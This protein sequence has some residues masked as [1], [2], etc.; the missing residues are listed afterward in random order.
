ML[1]ASG[2]KQDE[3][4]Y[5]VCVYGGTSAGVIAATAVYRLGKSVI[6]ISPEK[7]LGGLTS[8]GLGQTDIGNKYA[9]TGLARDFYRRIGKHYGRFEKWTFE[10]HV[11]EQVFNDYLKGTAITVVEGYHIVHARKVGNRVESILIRPVKGIGLLGHRKIIAREFIDCSY[12]GDMMANCKVS[13]TFGREA[14]TVY[15]ETLNGVQLRDKH[16]FPDGIDPFTR[17]GDPSSGLLWGIGTD[18][19]LPNGTG[20][21]KIQAYN[22]RLCLTRDSNNVIPIQKPFGYSAA[23]YELLRRLIAKQVL[24]GKELQLG[25]YMHIQEMPN[26]K[27]DINNNGPFSTDYI[28]PGWNYPESSYKRRIAIVKEH[29]DYIK[30][31]LYY[32]GHDPSVP[33]SLRRQMLE[34]GYAKDEFTDNGGFPWQLYVREA[35]RMLG[36]YVMTEANCTGK[37]KVGDGVGLA[38]YTMDSHNCD[39][40]VVHGMVKNEG[41][42]Q[43]GGFPPYPVSYRAI[44]PKI[45]ECTNLLVPVCLSSSHIAYG[46][47]RMEPVFMVLA[48]SAALAAA[49]A[50][51]GNCALQNVDVKALKARLANDPLFDGSPA[52]VLVDNADE[53]H[54]SCTGEWRQVKGLDQYG[55][56]CLIAKAP[57]K[58]K[59][60]ATFTSGE[61]KAGNWQ[62]YY[63]CPSKPADT[64]GWSGNLVFRLG[65]GRETAIRSISM[66]GMERNWVTLGSL[67]VSGKQAVSLELLADEIKAPVFADALLLVFAGE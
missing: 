34:W 44:I 41:D 21:N 13:Y 17:I 30:G 54:F 38:A 15:G 25:N 23:K 56:D 6:L 3:K 28:N 63:Y 60:T 18:S 8:G 12:E 5:D 40:I 67:H 9:I 16:Q 36:D 42:V 2:C 27:T 50:I 32:L 62:L 4:L 49:M 48:Q 10:P 58:G 66:E 11:A 39:R 19:L 31:F 52:D 53:T 46:S 35:R 1:F 7:H 51:E 55:E 64:V 22:F 29:E 14:D 61:L 65:N 37:E 59:Q 43:V 26:R 47:I 33:E 45:K 20:D 24:E 57:A